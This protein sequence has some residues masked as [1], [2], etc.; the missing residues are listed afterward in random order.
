MPPS[1]RLSDHVVTAGLRGLL[2]GSLRQASAT[3]PVKFPANLRYRT[4]QGLPREQSPWSQVPSGR[5]VPGL[6]QHIPMNGSSVERLIIMYPIAARQ[7]GLTSPAMAT[8]VSCLIHVLAG[9]LRM[10]G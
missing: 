4:D 2:F 8:V 5:W 7:C 6:A 9:G 3:N 10:H 1:W